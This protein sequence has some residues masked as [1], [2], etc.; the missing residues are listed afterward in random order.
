MTKS[1]AKASLGLQHFSAAFII[2]ARQYWQ[3]CQ[4]GWAW[5]HLLTLSLTSREL[6]PENAPKAVNDLIYS[7]AQAIR[8]MPKLR[9]ME[10]WNG[11]QGHAAL[12]RHKSARAGRCPSIVWRGNWDLK[13]ERRVVAAWE[14]AVGAGHGYLQ[15]GKELLSTSQIGSH[16]EAILILELENEVACPVSV[17]QIHR[18]H[19]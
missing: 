11:G 1:L 7:A 15:I 4:P 8:K 9:T 5:E 14:N 16:G 3:L 10:L 2:D 6:I 12:F 19:L 17:Q 13:L 18:E